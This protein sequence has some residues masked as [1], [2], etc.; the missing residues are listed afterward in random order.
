MYTFEGPKFSID[1]LEHYGGY[2]S[3][4]DILTIADHSRYETIHYTL[5]GSDPILTDNPSQDGDEIT[6]L[7]T[8]NTPKR[9]LI[10]VRPVSTDWNSSTTFNDSGWLYST[11]NPGGVGYE[12]TSGY[13]SLIS[14]DLEESMYSRNSTCY[15]RIPF[16]F[17]G[18][19]E[20]IGSAVLNIRYDDGFAAYLNGAE[21]ARRNADQILTWNS[22]ANTSHPDSEAVQS[23]SIDISTSLGNLKQGRNLLAI[24]GLNASASGSD[25]LI[26]AQLIAGQGDLDSTSSPGATKYSE[27]I[28][29]PHSTHVKARIFDG[30]TWSALSE[31]VFG[32][33][34]VTDYLRITEIMY[35]PDDSS[36]EFIELKNIGTETINLNLVSF[37]NG[38]DFTFPSFELAAGEYVILAQDQS[39][40]KARYG[41]TINIAGEY[42]GKLDNAGERITLVDATGQTILDFRY[43]DGW[44]PITDSDDFSLTI[45]DPENPDPNSWDEKDSWRPS[46]YAG[47]SPA[48]DDSGIL[49]SLGAVVINEILAHSHAEASD[50]IELHNTTGTAINIGGWY[51]SDSEN[52]LKKYKIAN[53][54]TIGPNQY[55]VLYENLHFGNINDPGCAEPF[56]LSENGE[57]LYLSS[58]HNNILT[59]YRTEEDFGASET[60]VSFGRYYKSSTSNY[61]FVAME[62]NTLGSANSNPKVGPIVISEIMYNPDWPFGTL[63]I[64]D[65][66]EYI[67][68]HNIT[69]EPV[70]L[71]DYITGEAWKFTDGIEFIFPTDVPAT[72]PA[73][74]YILLVKNPDVFSLHYPIVPAEIIF[75]PY[76]GKLSNAGER[77]ELGMPGDID[78][79]GQ[80][81]YIRID[82]V[83]YSDGSHPE[84]CPGGIDFWPI[85]PDGL[86]LSLTRRVLSEYGNDPA[87]WTAS[88]PSPG[89]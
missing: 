27:S 16:T 26:S 12:R 11:G 38:I 73:G 41:T 31:A 75:G 46:A 39:A 50:W 72:I 60:G 43:K 42:S 68:L 59:G 45:I 20:D 89:E 62:Q 58:A 74:G 83:N 69:A 6:V 88:A 4:S 5:D 9:V 33:G 8:E 65:E 3:S 81:H 71:Y 87:N 56:A 19:I 15:I 1:G 30:V 63:Y 18:D 61:N 54:T 32:V 13:E 77:L 48:L 40:L 78:N 21:I 82:R 34:P 84:N 67:E 22:S 14:L 23:E 44:Y 37:T 64:N 52:N 36:E 66:Y 70:T 29:L 25:F 55:Y 24:H 17:S 47:G 10:P 79:A 35:N 28:T 51:L 57:Q 53:G 86:G 76:D 49:P 7:V 85:E 2:M 80:R